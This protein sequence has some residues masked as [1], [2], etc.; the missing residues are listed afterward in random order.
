[1]IWFIVRSQVGTRPS[2]PSFMQVLVP[3]PTRRCLV[4]DV[5]SHFQRWE[6]WILRVKNNCV[7]CPYPSLQTA[8]TVSPN[9]T[10]LYVNWPFVISPAEPQDFALRMK[11]ERKSLTAHYDLVKYFLYM[12]CIKGDN[13]VKLSGL[14]TSPPLQKGHAGVFA[15]TTDQV[16]FTLSWTFSN[17]F[18]LI[19]SYWFAFL[20]QQ[21]EHFL[22]TCSGGM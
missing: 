10:P 22:Q 21:Y 17:C 14:Q 18:P 2:Q 7:I 5:K 12:L 4:K 1:M 20:P 8:S 13:T 6:C 11:E 16:C 15:F 19:S 9:S 3:R